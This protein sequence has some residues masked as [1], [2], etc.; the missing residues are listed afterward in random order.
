MTFIL[1]VILHYVTDVHLSS[2]LQYHVHSSTS[3][4]LRECK[5]LILIL[6]S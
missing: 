5:P 3:I 2:F 6:V 4:F 1:L